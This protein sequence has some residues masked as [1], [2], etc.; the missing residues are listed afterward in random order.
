LCDE[1][2]KHTRQALWCPI[3]RNLIYAPQSISKEFETTDS[4]RLSELK[5]APPPPK[6][7]VR[8]GI[9]PIGSRGFGDDDRPRTLRAPRVDGLSLFES[10]LLQ[11]CLLHL[12]L[13]PEGGQQ[14]RVFDHPPCLQILEVAQTVG[15]FPG[16]PGPR[17]TLAGSGARSPTNAWRSWAAAHAI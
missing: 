14:G 15:L 13:V 4:S 3:S 17:F 16:L 8:L 12:L 9:W 6:T 2:R 7:Q 10:L 1:P 5:L 11:R